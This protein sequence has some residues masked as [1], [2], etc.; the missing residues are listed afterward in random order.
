MGE[1]ASLGKGM[2]NLCVSSLLTKFGITYVMY[3]IVLSIQYQYLVTAIAIHNSS[4]RYCFGSCLQ[5][6]GLDF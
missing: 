4:R 5:L 6:T 3:I 2:N 1:E